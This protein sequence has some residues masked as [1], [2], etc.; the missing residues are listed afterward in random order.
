[1][2]TPGLLE[3]EGGIVVSVEVR[4]PAL[5]AELQHTVTEGLTAATELFELTRTRRKR[6][7]VPQLT[8]EST[9]HRPRVLVGVAP[10]TVAGIPDVV[11]AGHL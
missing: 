1:M 8:A 6:A 10:L 7:V 2:L 3:F 9:R 5:Q 4:E 11:A